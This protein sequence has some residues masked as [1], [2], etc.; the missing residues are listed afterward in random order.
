[1]SL[2]VRAVLAIRGIFQGGRPAAGIGAPLASVFLAGLAV[3]ILILPLSDAALAQ[4]Q[5]GGV[6]ARPSGLATPVSQGSVT[7]NWNDPG[8]AGITYDKILRR[9]RD[10]HEA[11]EFDTIKAGT[12]SPVASYTDSTVEAGKRYAYRVIAANA[13]GESKGKSND[14]VRLDRND[15]GDLRDTLSH[16]LTL[17]TV[18][19]EA[20]GQL[21]G[22]ASQLA[23]RIIETVHD[24]LTTGLDEL[25]R[26]LTNLHSPNSSDLLNSLRKVVS[27]FT[28]ATGI[29]PHAR[30]PNSLPPLSDG[31][32]MAVLRMVQEALTNIH[33]H[34]RAPSV[35]IDLN[36]DDG[37][38]TLLVR[39][40]GQGFTPFKD[41]GHGLPVMR[42][43]AAQLDG[44]LLVFGPSEGGVTLS[45]P[46]PLEEADHA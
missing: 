25:C 1:M 11:G 43:R 32:S 13:H 22:G 19:L 34:A 45:L 24:Q 9:D 6:S 31:H 37:A 14:Y 30:L 4:G 41:G 35:W 28:A 12:G 2:F 39:D 38:L 23:G 29:M 8:D 5:E 36:V 17:S 46:L 10:L 27:E 26:T 16:T 44:S 21:M 42:A 33:W 18:Q 40:D 15:A 20:A 7:L 3:P